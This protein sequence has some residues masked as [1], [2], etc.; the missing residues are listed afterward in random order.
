MIRTLLFGILSITGGLLAPSTVLAYDIAMEKHSTAI[1][2]QSG[3]SGSRENSLV[4]QVNIYVSGNYR[5]IEANGIPSHSTGVSSGRANPNRMTAQNHRF[6]TPAYGQLNGVTTPLRPGSFGVAV[7]GVPFNPDTAE[8]WNND[9]SWRYN[10]MFRRSG[11]DRSTGHVNH[12]GTYHYHGVP[13]ELVEE[14]RIAGLPLLIG[15]AADGFP[16][17]DAYGYEDKDDPQSQIVELRSSYLLKEGTRPN[18][19]GGKYTGEFLQ[20][21]EFIENLGDLDD[22]NGR[23]GVT[24]EYPNG[25]YYYVITNQF[26]N[27]PRGYKGTPDRSFQLHGGHPPGGRNNMVND[28][29]RPVYDDHGGRHPRPRPGDRF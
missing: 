16:I 1:G 20:D 19:P 21:Y 22:C 25:T 3:Y 28:G 18:G 15:Y 7:N 11:L 27:V 13:T 12:S 9:P 29:G 14:L 2:D 6:R 26:P 10:A 17:Y 4:N 24:P 23:F 5:F 8:T